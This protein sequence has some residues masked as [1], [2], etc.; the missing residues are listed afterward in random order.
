MNRE[1][2][3]S[4]NIFT[5]FIITSV[6]LVLLIYSNTFDSP[7]HYDDYSNIVEHSPVHW[8][9]LSLGNA[10]KLFE[11]WGEEGA[12]RERWL[13]FLTFAL[14]YYFG[15]L[16]VK[17]YH[18]VNTAIHIINGIL[19]YLFLYKTL[20]L[21]SLRQYFEREA[22]CISFLS[23]LLWL[24]NPVQTQAV[25]YIVQRMTSM[26]AMFYLLALL[27]YIKG[28]LSEGRI[29]WIWWM[30]FG[31][32]FILSTASKPL[33]VTLPLMIAIYEICFL[34]R[35]NFTDIL[36][37]KRTYILMAIVMIVLPA[38]AVKY[39]LEMEIP[40]GFGLKERV[41]TE[42]RIIMHYMALLSLPL[43]ERMSL[44][45]DY[46]LSRTLLEPLTTFFS[47][48]AIILFITWAA[49]NIRRRPLLSFFLF[50]FLITVSAEA[51]PLATE[52]IFEHRCYLPSMALFPAVVV[53]AHSVWKVD[54][55]GRRAA[56]AISIIVLILFSVNTYR[57]NL[58]WSDGSS[59]YSDS[60]RKYPR[61]LEAR[62]NLG[63]YYLNNGMYDEA[64]AQLTKARE[65]HPRRSNI[66]K[67]LWR[68][69][70]EK[71]LYEMAI[72]AIKRSI[73]LGGN[74]FE[75]YAALGNSYLLKGDIS[76]AE[77][78]YK[79]AMKLARDDKMYAD[80]KN[81]LEH[82]SSIKLEEEKTYAE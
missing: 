4:E 82:I 12:P 50:W 79:V 20:T 78:A 54:S 27:F 21:P 55:F 60:V 15:G 51:L 39:M 63:T 37:L 66:Y 49:L 65:L 10:K 64:I 61:S 34:Y 14:N 31:I 69:Y 71:G 26:A 33:S 30:L 52:L 62:L 13:S 57:R 41:Y 70:H 68:A 40:V 6:S 58:I 43:P 36:R 35:G 73:E 38:V 48:S 5:F 44:N 28:R 19:L 3:R 45:Y 24:S 22:G 2:G 67:Y 75:A 77:E 47:L 42:V 17:G 29:R 56:I 74:S 32:A 46:P 53:G 25:T 9:E 72:I 16:N 59:V 11:G 8:N 80:V 23:S 1:S 18:A 7:F 81:V 76:E